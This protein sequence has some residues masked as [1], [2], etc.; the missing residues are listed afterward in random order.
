MSKYKKNKIWEIWFIASI[1]LFISAFVV[2]IAPQG[3]A[4][5]QQLPYLRLAVTVNLIIAIYVGFRK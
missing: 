3:D 1:S 5:L 4:M 2:S